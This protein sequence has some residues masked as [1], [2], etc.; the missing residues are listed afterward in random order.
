[1]V[2][3]VSAA[4]LGA[5]LL[6]GCS[7]TSPRQ[8]AQ[9]FLVSAR[10]YLDKRDSAAALIELK[11][12]L[13]ETPELAE[14]R[15][16][17]GRA[18]LDTGKP[19]EAVVELRKALALNHPAEPIVPTLARALLAQGEGQKLISEHAST[20]LTDM[21]ADADLKASLAQAYF[22]AGDDRRADAVLA[23]ALKAAP[24]SAPA[25]M[26]QARRLASTGR[27]EAALDVMAKLLQADP[28]E[29][30]AWVLQGDLMVLSKHRRPGAIASYEK[31]VAL[32][33]RL[34][35]AHNG[36]LYELMA[37]PDSDPKALGRAFAALKAAL[38]EHPQATYFE[39]ALALQRHDLG[40][41]TRLAEQLLRQ[42]PADPNY[43][44][45][46]GAAALA[47]GDVRKAESLL[48]QALQ[49]APNNP[50][51]RRLLASTHLQAGEP[52]RALAA[53]APMLHKDTA[54]TQVLRMAAAARA[55]LGEFRPSL[56]LY[57]AADHVKPADERTRVAMAFA[58]L[59]DGDAHALVELQAMALV[60]DGMAADLAL[61]G[62]LVQR[63]EFKHAEAAVD[64]LQRK[65]PGRPLP[66]MLR[67]RIAMA[68]GDL[69]LA[70]TAFERASATDPKYFPAC[71]AL[72]AL[73]LRA[74][75]R[76]AAQR[77]MQVFLQ[78]DPDNVDALVAL[79]GLLEQ[80]TVRN[81]E[82][83]RLLTQ[84]IGVNPTKAA[85]RVLLVN[86]HL[87][88]RE[89]KRAVQAAQE[90]LAAMPADPQLLDA[91]GRAQLLDGNPYQAV[92]TFNHLV[93]V[94]PESAPA[95]L[96]LARAHL[97][98]KDGASARQHLL[99]ALKVQPGF[100]PATWALIELNLA[101][102]RAPDALE[103]AKGLQ[104]GM[105]KDPTGFAA[106]G[107]VR[108]MLKQWDGAIMAYRTALKWAPGRSD[109]AIRLHDL[110]SAAGRH[111]DAAQFAAGWR[112]DHANDAA[113]LAYLGDLAMKQPD[114]PLAERY[115]LAVNQL[116]PQNAP[117]LNNLAWVLLKQNKPGA[118]PY[119]EKAN[120]LRPDQAPLMDTLAM[121]LAADNQLPKALA[122]Q[123]KAIELHPDQPTLRVTLARL[124]L[125]A[126]NKAM[127][128]AELDRLTALGD[129]FAGQSQVA[130]LRR[131]VDDPSPPG[132][133][134]RR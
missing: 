48:T 53:L 94:Q 119:A 32:Q 42:A 77:R 36:L 71:A 38:P 95:Q 31:A 73:D 84:A 59:Q 102:H 15:L 12:A 75:Q 21:R 5:A 129:N 87:Q 56:A 82:V 115:F 131:T 14:A 124:Q 67:G 132:A 35:S 40:S 55:Q 11:N 57:E 70:R 26:L 126:G 97:A 58:R 116:Q 111:N 112:R 64:A 39:A 41:A 18:L 127:A 103:L 45:L 117:T 118:L 113:F 110:L 72:S 91:L 81:A 50:M 3:T 101:E 46:A 43:M 33:P 109:L 106:E 122:V 125:M 29:A 54:D 107:H 7:E 130:E 16:L 60:D 121:A 24:D 96:N 13:Q 27:L 74:S 28:A 85:T 2:A 20:V 99:R 37:N 93:A 6:I 90:A 49:L 30:P 25:C 68:R 17:L 66:D 22:N 51:L 9:A 1:M 86:H 133:A 63:R 134:A 89:A 80:A 62:A 108:S 83:E 123:Q 104:E 105:P 100:V 61:I 76:A 4:L 128:R 120:A 88:A 34:L 47:A 114:L 79:A 52:A 19:A 69:H 10:Q 78:R 65:Q 92:K 23:E 98:G 44:R 8:R